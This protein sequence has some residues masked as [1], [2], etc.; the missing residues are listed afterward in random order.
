M[1]RPAKS[2]RL[3][4]GLTPSRRRR[5][6]LLP[7]RLEGLSVQLLPPPQRQQDL[8]GQRGALC[9]D[10]CAPGLRGRRRRAAQR[11]H[12]GV[13]HSRFWQAGEPARGAGK[14]CAV[15]VNDRDRWAW[16]A[17][18]CHS[19]AGGICEAPRAALG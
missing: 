2:A 18:S 10:G 8:D 19:R 3:S 12:R 11:T 9:A 5:V 14:D 13:L 16:R 17:V 7:C 4:A 15:L 1:G 6:G